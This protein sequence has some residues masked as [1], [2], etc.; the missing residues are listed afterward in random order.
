MGWRSQPVRLRPVHGSAARGP[1]PPAGRPN[2]TSTPRV[3]ANVVLAE[4]LPRFL[5]AQQPNNH[6]AV[7]KRSCVNRFI[8]AG[9]L[10]QAGCQQLIID[11]TDQSV[12][13]AIEERQR[14][15][16]GVV[17]DADIGSEAGQLP[18][19]TSM[20]H[21]VP[22]PVGAE[23]PE[24]FHLRRPLGEPEPP[25]DK[26]PQP[27]SQPVA[28][29][30]GPVPAADV[31]P[32]QAAAA[33]PTEVPFQEISPSIFT[34]AQV[35]NVEVFRLSDGVRYAMRHSREIQNAKETLYLAALDLTLERH[36]W[37]PQF[38]GAVRADYA[39]Y[40]QINDFDHAMS[41][42]S[43]V[44][45][46][47]RLPYGGDVTAQVINTLMR[48]LGTH[49]TS[50]ETGNFI[51]SA[52]LPLLRGAGRAAYESRYSAERDLIYAVRAFEHFRREFAVRVAGDYFALQERKAAIAN[53]H[54]SYLSRRDDW[55]KAE[56][57]QKV[58]RSRDVFEATRARSTF[59]SAEAA[60]V[61]AKEQ[62]ALGL[63]RFKILLAMPV[64]ALID[65]VN[66]E[67]DQES[68]A[69]AGLMPEVDEA[70]AIDVALRYRLDLLTVADRVDD[71]Q[72][73]A[74]VA[75]NRILPD[76][77]VSGS[78]TLD[79]DPEHLNSTSYNTERATWRATAE[80]RLDDRKT[81]RNAYRASLVAFRRAQRD[82]EQFSDEVRADVRDALR[83]IEQQR[84]LVDIQALNVEEN[85]LRLEAAQA[86]YNLGKIGNRDVVEADDDLLAARNDY[87]RAVSQFRNA[88]LAFRRDTGTLR[89]DD[90]GRWS[91]K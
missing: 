23:I 59:R 37:T 70:T 15:A 45:V 32:G 11:R 54:K 26:S 91:G 31:P 16:V 90:Q 73:G 19:G 79:T 85:A 84:K 22:R 86:Q 28:P 34:S 87:A 40:G 76:L 9:A 65:V 57:V 43:D 61:S 21:F 18:A 60:L 42:V 51:L 6:D 80:M 35:A 47:Q 77:D 69:F 44:A 67:D 53:A 20:Y 49:I 3:P 7:M 1:M 58:G 8:L 72:R 66:Q 52:D 78:V 29:S 82:F 4:A 89:I 38:V 71:A 13:R 5:T 68:A 39:N 62:Y 30:T 17:A 12:Y 55:L 46:S 41:T 27:D 25:V 64:T 88:L 74:R 24:E 50:A 56:F 83:R 63:D 75:K 10:L 33:D 48:D 36:L 81:E 14:Q 2:F